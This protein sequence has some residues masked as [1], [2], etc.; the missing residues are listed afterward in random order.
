M[1]DWN[2]MIHGFGQE[3]ER[4]EHFETPH[5][6]RIGEANRSVRTWSAEKPL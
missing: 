1:D 5:S 4:I 6:Y 3:D 2:S